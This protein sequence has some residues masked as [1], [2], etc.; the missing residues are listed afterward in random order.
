MER[1]CI[2]R[3]ADGGG[4]FQG[5]VGLIGSAGV[6][7]GSTLLLA[8][9]LV[10]LGCQAPPGRVEPKP[11]KDVVAE[12]EPE[13]GEPVP[14]TPSVPGEDALLADAR[15]SIADGRVSADAR[16]RLAESEQPS[17]RRATRLLQAIDREEPSP[18]VAPEPEPVP[19]PEPAPAPAAEPELAIEDDTLV[20][21]LE[22]RRFSPDSAVAGWF[23][24]SVVAEAEPIVP[25]EDPLADL[26]ALDEP[27]VLLPI[28]LESASPKV[29]LT[30]LDIVRL[31]TGSLRVE[32]VGAGP[33]AVRI[34]PLG[35]HRLRLRLDDA[36]AMPGFVA[37]RPSQPELE[38]IDV[39]R[40]PGCVEVDLELASDWALV[41]G[42]GRSNG[43]ELE[44]AA[45]PMAE[46]AM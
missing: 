21:E 13:R 23:A 31:D 40:G 37:A 33:V 15:R 12:A 36:G 43:A 26:L 46:P 16:Q 1:K 42:R 38:V 45:I 17:H 27:G 41:L 39:R 8:A 3:G 29:I 34:Q 25:V 35:A 2:R 4:E 19:A 5:S 11:T 9:A 14:V 7:A 28:D 6:R 24:G 10:W 18:I 44:F 32:I 30:R 22:P 20:D